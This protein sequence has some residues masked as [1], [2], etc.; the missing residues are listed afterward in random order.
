MSE[1]SPKHG[2]AGERFKRIFKCLLCIEKPRLLAVLPTL[3]VA[4]P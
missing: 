3:G 2:M 1:A 4:A